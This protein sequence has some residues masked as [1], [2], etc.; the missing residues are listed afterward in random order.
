[1]GR[2]RISR[3]VRLCSSSNCSHRCV[4]G[5]G[6]SLKF[7]FSCGITLLPCSRCYWQASGAVQE[8]IGE[9]TE[10]QQVLEGADQL[11]QLGAAGGLLKIGPIGG[12]Q[13]FTAVR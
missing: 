1:R 3:T 11:G 9:A 8:S 12:D 4:S 13:R 7:R 5:M 10:A 6:M 2:E